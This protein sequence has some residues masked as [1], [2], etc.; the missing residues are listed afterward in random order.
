MQT[1]IETHELTK[2]Y[3]GTLAV[4]R[5]NLLIR[6]GEVYGFLGRNGAGK[7]TTIRMIMGL[8]RPDGGVIS[9]FGESRKPMRS[10]IGSIIETP[11]FY[12][13]LTGRENLELNRIL[14]GMPDRSCIDEALE[15][16]G[17]SEN[18]DR[19]V[20]GYSLGMKQRL[21][22]ARAILHRP[23]LLVLDE[24]TN[25]L[26]PAGIH[27]TRRLLRQLARERGMTIFLSSHMLGEVQQ[28]A[29]RVGIIDEGRLVSEVDLGEFDALNRRYLRISV[30]DAAA[31]TVI[32][33]RELRIVDYLVTDNE[34]I[35]A[36]ER[37]TES[38]LI[39]R[40]LVTHGIDVHSL[41]IEKDDLESYF[42]RLTT[43]G[44]EA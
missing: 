39:N 2:H 36:Y 31:A 3:G 13:N 37:L 43:G 38:H 5:L 42:L 32:L 26:D 18:A 20:G 44:S 33:E 19:K 34:E 8:V 28:L 9:L 35:R 11:G 1:T 27:D 29:D 40:A 15:T 30:S 25:G 14:L 10:R 41:S 6:P 23:E 12:Q 22:V 16:A 24:P 4:D 17:I 21:G 7:T